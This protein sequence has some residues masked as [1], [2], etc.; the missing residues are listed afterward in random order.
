MPDAKHT[1]VSI[2]RGLYVVLRHVVK[3]AEPVFVPGMGEEGSRS[4]L[5]GVS[6]KVEGGRSEEADAKKVHVI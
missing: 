3:R 1:V 6:W 2:P 5:E 4:G